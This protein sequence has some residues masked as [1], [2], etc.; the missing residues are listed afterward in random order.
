MT[1]TDTVA[2][3]TTATAISSPSDPKQNEEMD[4]LLKIEVHTYSY[5][6]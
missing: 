3:T 2:D 6:G 5:Y 4:E 1:E